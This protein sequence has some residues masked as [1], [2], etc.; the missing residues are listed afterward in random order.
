MDV[1]SGNVGQKNVIILISPCFTEFSKCLPE[2]KLHI[3]METRFLPHL[4]RGY[5]QIVAGL[6][7]V[8]P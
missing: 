3:H 8:V 2:R 6:M 7:I 4:P 1:L 5:S